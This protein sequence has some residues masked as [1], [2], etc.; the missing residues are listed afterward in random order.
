[1][2]DFQY[3]V[4]DITSMKSHLIR[5]VIKSRL[6]ELDYRASRYNA[7]MKKKMHKVDAIPQ[8]ICANAQTTHSS[9]AT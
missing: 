6:K 9:D 5:S 2:S 4:I 3:M 7:L 8:G 1:M